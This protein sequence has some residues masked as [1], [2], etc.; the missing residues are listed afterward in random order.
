LSKCD[1]NVSH[2]KF[3]IL[4]S[5]P[6]SAFEAGLK[7]LQEK[8]AKSHE[9]SGFFPQPMPGFPQYEKKVWKWDFEP[10]GNKSYTRKGWRLYAYV[11]NPDGPEP[12]RAQAFLA[13]DKVD[14]PDGNLAKHVAETLK[15]FLAEIIEIE[16]KPDKFRRMA[17]ENNQVAS[18]CNDCFATFLSA[19]LGEAEIA[20]AGHAEI[21]QS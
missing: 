1:L 4:S 15:T 8:V 17:A 12:I 20:E 10:S 19:D 5:V 6:E 13:Y 16:A 21:C 18:M 9:L 7:E 14:Q 2:P 11:E 3:R